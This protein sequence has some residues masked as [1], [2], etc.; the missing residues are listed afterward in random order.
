MFANI[1]NMA[2][3]TFRCT[4]RAK[5]YCTHYYSCSNNNKVW[6]IR[7]RTSDAGS[8][9]NHRGSDRYTRINNVTRTEVPPVSVFPRVELIGS[10]FANNRTGSTVSFWHRK[11]SP[12][13]RRRRECKEVIRARSRIYSV[14]TV[15]LGDG[16]EKAG[17]KL[18]DSGDRD[19]I[20]YLYKH[21]YV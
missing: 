16:A 2:C 14:Y 9:R 11:K 18:F 20:V 3:E 12:F 5:R 7:S 4:P 1:Q 13:R 17:T 6:I 19:G 10:R 21:I 15:S 8:V